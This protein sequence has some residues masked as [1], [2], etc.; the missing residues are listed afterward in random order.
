MK[1]SVLSCH[2]TV[3]CCDGN[4]YSCLKLFIHVAGHGSFLG[5]IPKTILWSL[6][7]CFI[8]TS[9]YS[10][11]QPHN[12][13][14]SSSKSALILPSIAWYWTPLGSCFLKLWLN[15]FINFPTFS[16]YKCFHMVYVI[17]PLAFKRLARGSTIKTH[18]P[19]P[20]LPH[21][22]YFI[23]CITF[24][25]QNWCMALWKCPCSSWIHN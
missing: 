21:V 12:F 8:T 25:F 17:F 1:R 22:V 14:T 7:V 16:T 6:K 5:P 11:D 18:F 10:W 9:L 23:V 2:K 24:P 13:S 19:F 15:F 3:P 20:L 4:L